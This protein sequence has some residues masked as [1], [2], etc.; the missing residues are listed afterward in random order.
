[1][2]T[3]LERKIAVPKAATA[4]AESRPKARTHFE[5]LAIAE[6]LSLPTKITLVDD[7]VTRGAQL[8]GA[9]WAIWS[10]R[11]DVEVSAFAV[12]R[13]ESDAA[14]FSALFDPR[15]G[16]IEWRDEECRRRP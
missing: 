5:S 8:F 12:I 15:S 4:A 9:A 16:K 2:L 6:P 10:M 1:M 3:C 13:T 7:V 14:D 11:P